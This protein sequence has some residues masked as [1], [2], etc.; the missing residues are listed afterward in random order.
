[1]TYYDRIHN[2]NIEELADLLADMCR[3][4]HPCNMCP[5]DNDCPEDQKISF[6]EWLT[7]ET[8]HHD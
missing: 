1:M 5:F 8:K 4:I 6:D 2:M 7:K 3:A